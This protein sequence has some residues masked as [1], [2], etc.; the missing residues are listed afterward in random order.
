L[1]VEDFEGICLWPKEEYVSENVRPDIV[2]GR[3]FGLI[4]LSSLHVS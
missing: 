2:E 4:D 1:D 3:S